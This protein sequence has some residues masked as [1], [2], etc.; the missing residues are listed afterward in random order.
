M[1]V[2]ALCCALEHT[3]RVLSNSKIQ[4]S[5]LVSLSKYLSVLFKYMFLFT[6]LVTPLV[7]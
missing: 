6:S 4:F 7:I 5:T 2:K 3:L 1:L